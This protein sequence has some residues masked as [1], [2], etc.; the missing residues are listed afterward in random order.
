MTELQ[1]MGDRRFRIRDYWSS[2]QAFEMFRNWRQHEVEQFRDWLTSKELVE[3]E[4]VLGAFYM[5][6]SNW[7]EGTGLVSA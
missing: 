6:D 1:W 4:T 2:H 5:D 3:H 7:D